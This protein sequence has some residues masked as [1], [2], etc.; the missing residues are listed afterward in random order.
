MIPSGKQSKQELKDNMQL[1]I[2]IESTTT[3][4]ELYVGTHS[5]SPKSVKHCRLKAEHDNT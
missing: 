2:L 3:S 5:E 4:T 1:L